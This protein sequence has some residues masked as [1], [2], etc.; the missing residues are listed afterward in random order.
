MWSICHSQVSCTAST[1]ER[2]LPYP[3]NAIT[4]RSGSTPAPA[5]TTVPSSSSVAP[6]FSS[7][8]MFVVDTGGS[9]S[10]LAADC[11]TVPSILVA[12]WFAPAGVGA[13]LTK[14]SRSVGV[15]VPGSFSTTGRTSSS[16]VP[17]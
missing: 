3:W 11:S 16:G 15:A 17:W 2:P 6:G 9:E 14:A 13:T 5:S 12:G 10:H 4:T 1:I 7:V 8:T